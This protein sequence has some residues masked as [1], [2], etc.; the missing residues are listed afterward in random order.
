MKVLIDCRCL[1]SPP[2]AKGG[3]AVYAEQLVRAL[4]ERNQESLIK[5]NGIEWM[6]F[7]NGLVDPRRHLPH[8]DAPNV[9]WIVTRWPNK[10][11]NLSS[12]FSVLRSAFRDADVVFLPNLNFIPRLP[13]RTKLVVTV[14]DLSFEH[15]ADCFTWKQ[16][17][18]HRFV[19]PRKL[20]AR[21]DAIIAVSETTK[22]DVVETYGIPEEKV[23]VVYPGID[24]PTPP[25][26]P[27]RREVGK[28]FFSPLPN[29]RGSERGWSTHTLP[30][31]F[32]LTLSAIEPRKNID[33]LIAAF[34]QLQILNSKFQIPAL[35]IAGI[36]GSATRTIQRQIACSPVRD[37]IHLIGPVSDTE[38]R[39]LLA[40]A[41]CFAYVSFWEGVGFPALEAMREGC[42]VVASTGGSLPEILGDAAL[43][44]DPLDPSAI[45]EAIAR[46]LTDEKLRT[47]LITRGHQRATQFRWD[48]AADRTLE[49]LKNLS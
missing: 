9:R 38:K 5:N 13:R 34:E 17:L 47:N 49:I 24:T 32:V 14:H 21:A 22:R 28:H 46:V 12:A 37:R 15:F 18:W 48:H 2:F 11:F 4:V 10:I 30:E 23:Y 20:L 41:A 7:V 6:L 44:V 27:S 3:V 35:V 1:Q 40:R 45:A 26:P 25:R 8:F 19:R 42:P 43:L 36:P 16:R 39:A 33:G 29:R 31:R